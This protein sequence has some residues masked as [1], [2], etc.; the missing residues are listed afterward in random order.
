M[1]VPRLLATL[2]NSTGSVYRIVFTGLLLYELVKF[3]TRK[4]NAQDSIYHPGD[5]SYRAGY[6]LGA[7]KKGRA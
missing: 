5:G 7:K 3:K 4:R 6:P 2:A 1:N